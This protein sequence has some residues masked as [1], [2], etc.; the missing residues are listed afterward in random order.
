MDN[1]ND[2]QNSDIYD[3]FCG[4]LLEL[5][6]EVN[7]INASFLLNFS[8][9]I[10]IILYDYVSLNPT[11]VSRSQFYEYMIEDLFEYLCLYFENDNPMLRFIK[12]HK[13]V[14][15]DNNI[16]DFS[17]ALFFHYFYPLKY[18]LN[19]IQ[20]NID[21]PKIY[22]RVDELIQMNTDVSQRTDDWY[23]MRNNMLTSS[24][25]YKCF[26]SVS[27]VNQ[28]ITEKCKNIEKNEK[29][30]E[31]RNVNTSSSLQYGIR[32]EQLTTNIY[33]N[34][35]NVKIGLFSCIPHTLYSFLGASPDGIIITKQSSKCGRIIEIKNPKSRI[36]TDSIKWDYWCQ[37]QLQLEVCDLEIAEFVETKFLEYDSEYEFTQDGGFLFTPEGKE[38]GIILY[39]C[40]DGTP[41][42]E[43]KPLLMEENEYDIWKE[44]KIE[45]YKG[46]D[47]Q[48]MGCFYW[49][50]DVYHILYIERNRKWFEDNFDKMKS[51]W[52]TILRERQ[53]GFNHRLPKSRV[54][55]NSN[56]SGYGKCHPSLI[57]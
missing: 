44:E 52:D 13:N 50:L 33:E 47:V 3:Y 16:F 37:V 21:Y 41:I 7:G 30:E 25:I 43:Y 17:F 8:Y 56:S 31:K 15:N 51:V 26:G 9:L 19:D 46:I 5:N 27:D 6:Y 48:F 49:K 20:K 53:T 18:N 38:K 45:Y 12:F 54:V 29:V 23:T 10:I 11:F 55:K 40:N 28:L 24:N 32:Y 14:E 34:R 39:F 36:I 42:Y 57:F 22:N 4:C 35:N 1:S 2:Y